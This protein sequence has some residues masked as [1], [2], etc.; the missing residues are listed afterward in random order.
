MFQAGEIGPEVTGWHPPPHP[1]RQAMAG[2]WVELAPLSPAHAPALWQAIQGRPELWAYMGAG[3]FG[4]EAAFA[5]WLAQIAPG[6]DPQFW[7][8]RPRGGDWVGMASYLRI[9][10]KDGVIE[11]GNIL[12]APALQGT[13]AAT[14]AMVLMMGFAFDQGYRRYEWKCNALNLPSRRAAQRLGFSFEGVFRQHMVIKGRNRD[15]AWFSITD[16]DWPALKAAYDR[17]LD[18]GNFAAGRQVLALSDLT[19]PLLAARDPAL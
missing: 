18:P 6:V 8:I 11:V 17:W 13:S 3:P 4:S 9:T 5:G 14:E 16:A 12:F 1:P 7:A 2:Q 19:R 15:T 10:P